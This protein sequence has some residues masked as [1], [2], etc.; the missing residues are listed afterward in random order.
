MSP[1]T[2]TAL[3]PYLFK[4]TDKKER[5]QLQDWLADKDRLISTFVAEVGVQFLSAIVSIEYNYHCNFPEF[6]MF[7]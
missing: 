5:S 2:R 1:Q 4:I 6:H 7:C 3:R